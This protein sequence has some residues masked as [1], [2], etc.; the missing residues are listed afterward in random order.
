MEGEREGE[1]GRNDLTCRRVEMVG[2]LIAVNAE[3]DFGVLGSYART[4]LSP[5]ECAAVIHKEE[6]VT[7]PSPSTVDSIDFPWNQRLMERASL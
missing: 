4:Q 1:G 5:A 6:N 3:S 2:K 7:G